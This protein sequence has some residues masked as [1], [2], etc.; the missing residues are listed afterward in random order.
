[1]PFYS[2][3]YRVGRVGSEQLDTPALASACNSDCRFVDAGWEETPVSIECLLL[4]TGFHTELTRITPHGTGP[5]LG[6]FVASVYG[7]RLKERGA[8][9]KVGASKDRTR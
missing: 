4:N 3:E 6:T 7:F 2:T 8:P 9:R 5:A 1:M